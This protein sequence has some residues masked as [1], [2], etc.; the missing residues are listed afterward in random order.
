[1]TVFSE[2]A[3]YYDLLYRDKDYQAEAEYVH[4]LIQ[5]HVPGARTV[6]NLGCGSGRHDR[7]LLKLG[8][9][10]TGVDCSEEMLSEAHSKGEGLEYIC[11][12]LCQVRL[13]RRFDAVLALF[14]VFSYQESNSDLKAAFAALQEHLAPGGI[15]LFDCW[16]GPAVLTDRP[17][18]RCKELEDGQIKVLRRAVPVMHPNENLVDVCYRIEVVN[19]DNGDRKELEETHRM[20][21]LFRP[22]VEMLLEDHSLKPIIFEEWVSG[23]EPGF[24]SWNVVFGAIRVK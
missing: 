15:A 20:R 18:E 14:H 11:A 16:Y 12:D 13:G 3:R 22:E 10:V 4:G 2:Y 5:A 21:Y 23:M 8:Y 19:K 1:M 6:L 7:E 24:G 17:T 9:S